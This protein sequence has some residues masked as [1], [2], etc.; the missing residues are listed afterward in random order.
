[1]IMGNTAGMEFLRLLLRYLHLLGF[2]L[3]LGGFAV[4]YLAGRFKVSVPMRAASAQ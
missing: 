3:L 4:E 1:M 2:A